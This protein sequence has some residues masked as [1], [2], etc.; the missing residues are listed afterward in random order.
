MSKLGISNFKMLENAP[1]ELPDPKAL[2]D[3]LAVGI[4]EQEKIFGTVFSTRVIKHA[5]NFISRRIEEKPREDIKNLDE[6]SEYLLSILDKYPTP[7]CAVMYAQYK[8]ENDLQGKAGAV[9]RVGEMGFHKTFGKDTGGK[10]ISMDLDNLILTLHKT[11][12]TLKLCPKEF[13]Y[14][15]NDDGSLDFILPN[16]YFKDGCNQAFNEGLLIRSGGRIY[17]NL[18]SSLSQYL[19]IVT[20]NEWDFECLEYDKPYCIIRF[21]MV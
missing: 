9:T 20:G 8:T 7:Y 13:G 19:K 11:A 1:Y 5:L 12:V 6:L 10:T 14:R 18:G 21:F 16:C 17:C 2:L 4:R 15:K 3:A